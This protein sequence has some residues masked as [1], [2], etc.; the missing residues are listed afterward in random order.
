M[1][2]K[3]LKTLFFLSATLFS[4]VLS[5]GQ[6]VINLS[7]GVNNSTSAL[8]PLGQDDDTWTVTGPGNTA[9][10]PKT[11]TF[12]SWQD[13]TCSRWL[14]P[15]LNPSG[16]VGAS[17]AGNYTYRASFRINSRAFDCARLEIRSMGADNRITQLSINGNVYPL[18]VPAGNHYNPLLGAVTLTI[19][20]AHLNASG[21]NTVTFTVLDQGLFTGFNLCANLEIGPKNILPSLAAGPSSFCQG[22]P[23]SFTAS[24]NP[25]SGPTTHYLWVLEEST[26]G[27][28]PVS[29]GFFWE[30]WHTGTPGAFTFPSSINP[31]CN[32]Y[33]RVRLAA[34]NDN[35]SGTCL[36]WA[37]VSKV[38]YYSCKPT[39]NAGP[40]KTICQNTSDFVGYFSLGTGIT[41]TWTVGNGPVLGTESIMTVSPSSTTTYT[42]TATNAYGCSAS[43]Q[44][45]VTVRPNNPSFNI[46]T[47]TSNSTYYTV[48]VTP[49]AVNAHLQPGFGDY[50]GLDGIS[51]SGAV[52]F[53]IQNPTQWWMYPSAN[54][55]AGFD[56]TS[57]NYSNLIT[58]T[59]SAPS[60]GRFKYNQRYKITRGTWNNYCEWN[61]MAYEIRVEK[62]AL[63]QPVVHIT[64]VA[65]AEASKSAPLRE[66]KNTAEAD[67]AIR[68]YP[69]P[70]T[71]LLNISLERDTETRVD[72]FD[73]SG[74]KI[75]SHVM[76]AGTGNLQVDLSG[77]AKGLYM[78]HIHSGK[79]TTSHK[80]IL[81]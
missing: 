65:P 41:Y 19:N 2:K 36:G 26:A 27:G 17:T 35:L 76:A 51:P 80:V 67:D 56:H 50:W 71:G 44:V 62:T 47:N 29:G 24:L 46:S 22:T 3:S 33:Y 30:L 57:N 6:E 61:A 45:T 9:Y 21:M 18:T 25:G 40:D 13:N 31:P 34:V 12:P 39:V 79:E 66:P 53:Y 28:T 38:I 74:R 63:G 48:S 5:Y 52:D 11:C 37:E 78:V 49:V 73:L 7:T 8:I 70:S 81:Q 20:P 1:F 64:E 14:S 15:T 59:T 72:V 55:F 23:L 58:L 42:L 69:N 10:I 77:Y 75:Q 16:G 32:K 54:T 60:P 43:D 68:I 4:G